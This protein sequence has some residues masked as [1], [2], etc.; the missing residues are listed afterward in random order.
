MRLPTHSAG[1]SRTIPYTS[2]EHSC[3]ARPEADGSARSNATH[4]TS[5]RLVRRRFSTR[6]RAFRVH[7]R[8]DRDR[9]TAVG[10]KA[11][12]SRL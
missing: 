8:W 5:I 2:E 1:I 11:C 6:T 9:E 10:G 4:R 12:A 7:D 3:P